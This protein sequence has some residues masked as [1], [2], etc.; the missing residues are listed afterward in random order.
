ML[1]KLALRTITPI[2]TMLILG[3]IVT[4]FGSA[5]QDDNYYYTYAEMDYWGGTLNGGGIARGTKLVVPEGAL[6]ETTIISMEV[7]TDRS[8]YISFTF[9]PHG[10]NFDV[11]V[12]IQLSW[13]ALKDLDVNEDWI[14]WYWDEA[15]NEWLE[16]NSAVF[17]PKRKTLT[18][19]VD[20]FSY[21][22]YGRR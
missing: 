6:T 10:T 1:Q 14:L 18:L 13:V 11:P 8:S 20:H 2:T 22:Y 3:L 4:F 16:E 7:C 5:A 15:L 21:Y 19:Y 12:E 9:G 17:D